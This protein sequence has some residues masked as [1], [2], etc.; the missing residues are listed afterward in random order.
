MAQQLHRPVLLLASGLKDEVKRQQ[1]FA[2]HAPEQLYPVKTKGP[3]PEAPE[4]K[5]EATK[6]DP[7]YFI[8]KAHGKNKD[9]EIK[10]TT[11]NFG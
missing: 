7:E 6:P 3:T 10:V 1:S 9:L 5:D 8:L 2:S 4:S 11:G